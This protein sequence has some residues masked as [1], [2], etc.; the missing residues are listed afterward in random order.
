[1]PT[2]TVNIL[3]LQIILIY[4]CFFELLQYIG[5]IFSTTCSVK[6][7]FYLEIQIKFI[8]CI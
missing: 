6:S 2:L 8:I 4:R 7:L 5:I 3:S 1:M